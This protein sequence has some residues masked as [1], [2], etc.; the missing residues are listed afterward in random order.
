METIRQVRQSLNAWLDIDEV[1]W[2]QR[3]RINFLKEGDQNTSFF[4]TKASNRKQRNW[5]QGLEDEY[6][7]WQEGI[8]EI[9]YVAT[10]YFSTLFTSSQPG[11]MTKLLNAISPTVMDAMNLMLTRDFQASEV[12]RALKQMHPNTAPGQDGLPPL[13]Y[14]KFWALTGTCVT[15]AALDFLNHGMVPPN[16]NDTQIVLIPK[17]QNPR[18]IIEYKPIS[19]CNVAYKIASKAVVNRLKSVLS[20]IVSENQS[21]FTKGHFIT[22]NVLVAFE[23]M[24]HISQK[25]SGRVGEMT[26]K[27]DM[28]KAYDRVEW[29]CL[30]NVMRKMGVHQNM[31]DVIMRCITTVT[32]SIRING[33]TRGRIVPSRGLRQGDPLSPYLFLFCAE[34]LSA[35]LRHAA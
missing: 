25:K 34:G 8:H 6:G 35:L 4:H 27:L 5:I 21:A 20:V 1:M 23:T 14:Q 32:Y 19:I 16:Y 18:K 33:Q 22:D 28:S 11:E 2:K 3:S 17:V 31:I 15:Q 12:A 30:E 9:E 26:L 13:F 24:H 29:T 7:L 10:Q